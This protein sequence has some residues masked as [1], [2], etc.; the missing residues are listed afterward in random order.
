MFCF[1][2]IFDTFV[3]EDPFQALPAHDL[4]SAPLVHHALLDEKITFVLSWNNTNPAANLQLAITTPSGSTLHLDSPGVQSKFGPS[5]H[6]VKVTKLPVYG[7]RDG[8]WTARAVRPFDT[9]VNGFTSRSFANASQGV[10]LVQNEIATLCPQGCNR[11]L[12]YE[13]FCESAVTFETMTSIYASAVFGQTNLGTI[14]RPANATAFAEAL[15]RGNFDL[16]IYSS[17]Y[18]NSVQPYDGILTNLLCGLCKW[19]YDLVG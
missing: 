4:S 14:T 15:D 16:L 5:W 6:V 18:N 3:G 8:D 1:A 17:Q 9:Y 10:K 19:Y 2:S 11:T 13:D 7:E 12:Y